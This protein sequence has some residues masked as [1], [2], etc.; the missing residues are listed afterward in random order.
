LWLGLQRGRYHRP[1]LRANHHFKEK[2]QMDEQTRRARELDALKI[3]AAELS[4]LRML[5]EY[6]IGA[7]VREV[8]GNL[9]VQPIEK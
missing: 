8:E 4:K 9:Y 2:S 7:E 3:I 1:R 6:E 5:R